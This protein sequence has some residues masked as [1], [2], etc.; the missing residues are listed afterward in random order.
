MSAWAIR[1]GALNKQIKLAKEEG[2]STKARHDPAPGVSSKRPSE[3]PPPSQ[4]IDPEELR[5]RSQEA[6]DAAV[7]GFGGT[8]SYMK[9]KGTKQPL[10]KADE[11]AG[12]A[13]MAMGITPP[14]LKQTV[15]NPAPTRYATRK[16]D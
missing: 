10:Q 7:R 14:Q 1:T 6:M 13:Y 15:L 12:M 5:R 9:N 3:L 8:P 2:L 4:L 16:A 11:A